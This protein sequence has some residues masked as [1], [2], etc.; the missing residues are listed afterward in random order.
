[1]ESDPAGQVLIE[2]SALID[3]MRGSPSDLRDSVHELI[4]S[5]QGCITGAVMA[6]MIA[7][8]RPPEEARL[9]RFLAA[10]P[11]LSDPSDVWE[12]AGEL[13]YGLRRRGRTLG[14]P[15]ALIAAVALAHDVP[16]LTLDSDFA[17]IPRLRLWRPSI[18]S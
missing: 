8:M 15:D 13:C 6:E 4:V 3:A 7:G 14:L 12:R 10:L 17:D 5:G 18:N 16:L 1:M 9:R 11:L 2:T